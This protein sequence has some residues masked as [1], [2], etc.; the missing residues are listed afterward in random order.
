MARILLKNGRLWDGETFQYAEVLTEG[1]K[2]ITIS[3]KICQGADFV[4]DAEGKTVVPGLIDAHAHLR[5]LSSHD[6]GAQTEMCCLPFGVTAVADAEG[7]HGDQRLIDA[8]I[9]KTKVFVK[10]PIRE[11]AP[12]FEPT[13]K[14][15]REYGNRAVGLKVFFDRGAMD[16]QSIEP[17]RQICAFAH[18]RNL[19]V[20]VHSTNSPTPMA[21]IVDALGK[22]DILTHIFHGGIHNA[23]E[24]DYK[25]LRE[26]KQKGI[27]LDLGFEGFVH[28]DFKLFAD[29]VASGILPDIIG[30]DLTK[31]SL[32]TRGGR[33][34]LTLCMSAAREVGMSEDA[35]F[36]AVTSAPAK[37]LGWDTEC[38]HLKEGARADLAVL[39]YTEES[40]LELTDI[41]GN[42]LCAKKGYR[43]EMT[44]AN[45]EVVYRRK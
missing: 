10:V 11:N 26:A 34:G 29:A 32:N 33:Y 7:V 19:I 20:M 6:I 27:V 14:K 43:C 9:V 13:I 30:T 21:D 25:G 35:I 37:A 16:V 44:I 23:S 18:E 5:G 17:L 15:L 45:G 42:S 36:R 2:I 39:E 22:G 3:E 8:S 1:D 41:F 40:G 12:D 24:D 38:G 31:V 4:V 28:T